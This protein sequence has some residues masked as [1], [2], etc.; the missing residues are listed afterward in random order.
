MT[1]AGG[2]VDR[3]L[4]IYVRVDLLRQRMTAMGWGAEL[5]GRESRGY[6]VRGRREHA[7]MLGGYGRLEISAVMACITGVWYIDEGRLLC[8]KG[9]GDVGDWS[10]GAMG[11][12]FTVVG[13]VG[14]W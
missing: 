13:V 12:D 7:V 2:V 8:R 1:E 14:C 4:Q 9:D 5:V 10:G 6:G 11:H 3:I